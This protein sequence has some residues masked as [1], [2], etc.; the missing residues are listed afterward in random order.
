[1]AIIIIITIVMMIVIMMMTIIIII[2]IMAISPGD[3]LSTVMPLL[4]FFAQVDGK[5]K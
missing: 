2:I 1:M 3:F 5:A 4:G